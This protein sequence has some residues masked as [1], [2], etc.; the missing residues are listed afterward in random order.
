M[1]PDVASPTS[2]SRPPSCT[3]GSPVVEVARW[4]LDTAAAAFPLVAV[5]STVG[6]CTAAAAWYCWVH[7]AALPATARRCDHPQLPWRCG[8]YDTTSSSWRLPLRTAV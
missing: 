8:S 6:A 3:L 5:E 7:T 2:Q 4:L 1:A